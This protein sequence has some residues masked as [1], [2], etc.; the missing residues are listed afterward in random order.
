MASRT[1]I[2]SSTISPGAPDIIFGGPDRP[3]RALRDVL[4][5]KIE[6]VPS[7][8]A[9]DWATYYFRDQALAEALIAASD[10]GVR[11]RLCVEGSPRRADVNAAV[12]ARLEAHGLG[13]G[14]R[15]Q[16]PGRL[17]ALHPH[18]HLKVYAFS[19][20]AP[21]AYVGSF[22]PS[23]DLPENDP[24]I[25]AEI[26]DQDRGHNLLVGF[27]DPVLQAGLA[28]H[29]GRLVRHGASSFDRF[30]PSQNRALVS[31][32]TAIHFFPRLDPAVID[33]D[34]DA[35]GAGTMIRG[36]LSHLK[37][38][39]LAG[40]L[41]AAARRGADVSLLVHDTER[42]VPAATVE[43]LGAGGI[44]IARY[45]HPDGLPLHAKFLLIESAAGR[46]SAFGSFNFNPRSRYL[47]HE[48]LVR[49]TDARIADALATRFE[50]IAAE[51]ASYIC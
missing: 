27:T 12:V 41:I 14:L 44:R 3:P 23:G 29:I 28:A 31:R 13:S 38:G 51:P 16:R 42:R 11:V 33:A 15:V 50:S 43:Q 1:C 40:R 48:L 32:G 20:P 25:V 8:G 36:A 35:A 17:P 6:A 2:M 46:L 19:H 4:Q 5:A 21:V 49:S 47:N 18:L 24:A 22:N 45:V 26:G 30:R 37:S 10:R 7:G 9:I 39:P 34:V